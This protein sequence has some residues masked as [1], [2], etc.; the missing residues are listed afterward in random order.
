MSTPAQLHGLRL[1]AM[2]AL[3]MLI[4]WHLMYEGLA[5]LSNPYWTSAGFL[6]ASQGPFSGFF[7]WLAA[8]PGRLAIVD[9]L[10]VWGL[11]LLGFALIV[12]LLTRVSTLLAIVLLAMYYLANPP[13]PGIETSIPAEGSYVIVNKTLIELAAL[14]VLFL[15][16]TGRQVGLDA[17][18]TRG[19][20]ND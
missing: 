8:D 3:R 14:V 7:V 20:S 19:G 12:G 2:V 10:N 18:L 6:S 11:T 13:L 16:P 5:K 9:A 4:G 15:F 1:W 17:Y